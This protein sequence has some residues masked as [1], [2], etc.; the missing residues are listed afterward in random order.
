[1]FS[2]HA[3][4]L[5]VRPLSASQL[6]RIE[7]R[8]AV[9]AAKAGHQV[10]NVRRVLAVIDNCLQNGQ[11]TRQQLKQLGKWGTT[12]MG[13]EYHARNL[14]WAIFALPGASTRSCTWAI[15]PRVL[16]DRNRL[17]RSG[18]AELELWMEKV[19][20]YWARHAANRAAREAADAATAQR[21]DATTPTAQGTQPGADG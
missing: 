2:R 8:K 21:A 20:H 14:L 3:G 5:R 15:P 6:R 11:F 17:L 1:M 12:R 16:D 10:V 7:R 18:E 19:E 4:G 9:L 13:V